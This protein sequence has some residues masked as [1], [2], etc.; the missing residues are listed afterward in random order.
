[1][2]LVYRSRSEAKFFRDN[3]KRK[4]KSCVHMIKDIQISKCKKNPVNEIAINLQLTAKRK[5]R[6]RNITRL[7]NQSRR[8]SI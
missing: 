4:K 2:P 5:K 6:S 1:V 8:K 3:E 7:G